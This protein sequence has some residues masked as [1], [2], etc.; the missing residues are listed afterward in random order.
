M[1]RQLLPHDVA[2]PGPVRDNGPYATADQARAQV[3]AISRG[4]PNADDL[5][6][7]LALSEALL[8]AGVDVT[9][10]ERQTLTELSQQ[11]DPATAQVIAG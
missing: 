9:A 2:E 11:L 10:Y 5:G 3:S 6:P 1:D 8:L 4:I 7:G